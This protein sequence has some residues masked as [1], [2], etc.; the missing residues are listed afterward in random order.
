MKITT[1]RLI[2]GVENMS[3]IGRHEKYS[4]REIILLF[5]GIGGGRAGL[6]NDFSKILIKALSKLPKGVAEWAIEH[7]VFVSALETHYAYTLNLNELVEKGKMG[8]IV[9]CEKLKYQNEEE[10]LFDIAHEI[11]H[12]KL[13][14]STAYPDRRAA[15][16]S[17]EKD[18]READELA[19]SWLI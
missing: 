15:S 6:D 5:E 7:A 17:E 16:R 1:A 18:E 11:A 14:H 19:K 2:P 8:L 12:A 4:K 13:R 9:L 10:Q 3:I